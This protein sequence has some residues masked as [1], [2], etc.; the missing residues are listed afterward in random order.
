MPGWSTG[1]PIYHRL[2][3]ESEAYQGNPLVDAI[4]NPY[5]A[6]LMAWKASIDNFDRDFLDPDTCRS[7]VL[8]WLAQLCGFTGEYW[9]PTWTDA[10]KR[11]LIRKSHLFIWPYKGTQILLEWLLGLFEIQAR[12][13]LIGQFLVGVNVVG[14]QIGGELL[15]YWILLPLEY[16]RT[17]ETWALTERFNRLYMPCFAES[18]VCYERFYVGF[19][20]V[21]DPI[22]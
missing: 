15:R 10:Q 1:R 4:T 19:S 3:A 11:E 17:S 20:V 2:P 22:F 13:Y 5:D 21:G 14:D 8:D 16:R 6:L 9:D 12:I 7:D 18:R